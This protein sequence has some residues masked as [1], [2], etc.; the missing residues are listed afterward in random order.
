MQPSV[1]AQVV[2]RRTYNRPLNEEGT[3]F[4]TWNQTVDRV[5]GHQR[6]LWERQLS[7]PLNP[8]EFAELEDLRAHALRREASPSGRTLWLGGTEV[9]RRRE[10]SMFNCAFSSSESVYDMVD[11]VWILLQGGGVGR[12]AVPWTQHGFSHTNES[13]NWYRDCG[14]SVTLF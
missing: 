13:G 6:W 4:E 12:M 3:E 5:I 1:R 10:A 8:A 9:S 11:H 14:N 2:T 7:R